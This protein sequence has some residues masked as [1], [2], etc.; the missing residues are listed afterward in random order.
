M[1]IVGTAAAIEEA[2]KTSDTAPLRVNITTTSEYLANAFRRR[3]IETWKRNGW[4]TADGN[5][6]RNQEDWKRL[7][8]AAGDAPV[9]ATLRQEDNRNHTQAEC[10]RLAT[11]EAAAKESGHTEEADNAAFRA[12]Y[13]A[14]LRAAAAAVNN[15][16]PKD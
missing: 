14:G 12:G 4:T 11:E 15:L 5:P 9:Y 6:V 1:L 16:S 8:E 10:L 13:A 3:W 2:T 7:M